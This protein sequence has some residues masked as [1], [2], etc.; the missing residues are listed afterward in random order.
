MTSMIKVQ[1][2]R[3]AAP[4]SRVSYLL[5]TEA[6]VRSVQRIDQ[7][8]L[9]RIAGTKYQHLFAARIFI[10]EPIIVFL[11][12]IYMFSHRDKI[13]L[14]H[15]LE[16]LCS[17]LAWPL[18]KVV[19]AQLLILTFEVDHIVFLHVMHEVKLRKLLGEQFDLC[20]V[21]GEVSGWRC[22]DLWLEQQIGRLVVWSCHDFD[23]VIEPGCKVPYL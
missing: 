11:D 6:I 20:R 18:L 19:G 3:L 12:A 10:V 9:P 4:L 22:L 23:L 15:K 5:S 16:A 14:M 2:K 17:L 7:R 1:L 13:D 21:C 8:A